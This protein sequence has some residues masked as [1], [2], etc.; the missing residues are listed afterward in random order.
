MAN[1]KI[2]NQWGGSQ[3]AW[4]AAGTWILGSRPAQ[5]VTEIKISSK[6]GGKTFNGTMNYNGEGPIG[7]RA[8]HTSGNNYIVENQWGGAQAPWNPG[9]SWI[10][11]DRDNQRV[12]DLSLKISS[13]KNLQG[14]M[15]Y[16][17][18]SPIGTKSTII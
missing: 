12:I 16:N 17:N 14:T 10:I 13:G 4:N 1:Y 2:E 11:G 8:K 6:D 18:E 5:Y 15:T 9:G 3:A 7:F